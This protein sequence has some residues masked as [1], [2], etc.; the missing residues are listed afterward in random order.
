MATPL[1][2]P[3][4]FFERQVCLMNDTAYGVYF[5]QHPPKMY[6]QLMEDRKMMSCQCLKGY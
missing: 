3:V 5:A 4:G 2:Y 1:A 6:R